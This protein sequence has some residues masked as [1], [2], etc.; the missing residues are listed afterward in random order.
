MKAWIHGLAAAFISGGATAASSSIATI[1]IDPDHFSMAHP[2][3][4][5]KVQL[6]SFLV[7]GVAGAYGYL[8]QSPL[9]KD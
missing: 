1:T 5:I 6:V 8:K 2:A 7:A 4:L 9:P 3:Q